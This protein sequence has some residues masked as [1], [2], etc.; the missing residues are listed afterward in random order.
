MSIFPA[1]PS[2]RFDYDFFIWLPS[3]PRST[4]VEAGQREL[5][6]IGVHSI[7]LSEKQKLPAASAR[8]NQPE[9]QYWLGTKELCYSASHCTSLSH[10]AFKEKSPLAWRKAQGQTF[11][12]CLNWNPAAWDSHY[13]TESPLFIRW[14]LYWWHLPSIYCMSAL[15]TEGTELGASY[16]FYQTPKYKGW[17]G[18][19]LMEFWCLE[20]RDY[21]SVFSDFLV[22]SCPGEC[23]KGQKMAP[24]CRDWRLL[25]VSSL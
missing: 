8:K 7:F 25:R 15:G 2:S 22:S 17:P 18:Q 21:L 13:S 10:L 19:L 6:S 4:S 24:I 16:A 5:I 11:I 12:P 14:Y 1:C 3:S 9:S 23:K 20:F